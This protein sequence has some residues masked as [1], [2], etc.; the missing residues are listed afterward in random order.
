[1]LASLVLTAALL[2]PPSVV[3][4]EQH[5]AELPQA[6]FS[7]SLCKL[8]QHPHGVRFWAPSSDVGLDTC[9]LSHVTLAY[10]GWCAAGFLDRT[11]VHFSQSLVPSILI[12]DYADGTVIYANHAHKS[13]AVTGDADELAAIEFLQTLPHGPYDVRGDDLLPFPPGYEKGFPLKKGQ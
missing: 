3:L 11:G 5:K 4:Y 10:G 8:L 6:H 2:M 13:Q 1:M 12:V 9:D 7:L